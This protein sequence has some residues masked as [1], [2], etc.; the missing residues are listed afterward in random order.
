VIEDVIGL[1][2][3]K[4]KADRVK[5]ARVRVAE[6]A[7]REQ[8]TAVRER[9]EGRCGEFADLWL[10]ED[11][12]GGRDPEDAGVEPG[13]AVSGIG[14]AT[15]EP[16]REDAAVGEGS[17]TGAGSG[18]TLRGERDRRCPRAAGV[19]GGTDTGARGTWRWVACC[20]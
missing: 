15:I 19:G 20:P 17:E 12:L 16:R 18:I 3:A 10:D 5:V 1:P 9:G 6:A 7:I 8:G 2:L 4:V 13:G 14:A 11:V